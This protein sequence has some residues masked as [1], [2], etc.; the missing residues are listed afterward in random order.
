MLLAGGR[1]RSDAARSDGRELHGIGFKNGKWR[2]SS[3]LGLRP[4]FV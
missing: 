3:T 1:G 4:E 2:S